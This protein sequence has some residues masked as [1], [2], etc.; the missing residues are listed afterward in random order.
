MYLGTLYAFNDISKI[1]SKIKYEGKQ[2]H[3]L[4]RKE[5]EGFE[6]IRP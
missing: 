6:V 1:L 2:K 4:R 3:N 5:R